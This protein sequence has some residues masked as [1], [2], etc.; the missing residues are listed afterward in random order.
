MLGA[1]QVTPEAGLARARNLKT[2]G[3]PSQFIY[4]STKGV[5]ATLQERGRLGYH[6]QAGLE[7]GTSRFLTLRLNHYAARGMNR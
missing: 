3:F 4:Q 7:P 1:I 2:W 6:S 5:M